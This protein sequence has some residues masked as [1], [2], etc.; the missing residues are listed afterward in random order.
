MLNASCVVLNASYEP[1]DIKPTKD[2][3]ID[4]ILDKA[5]PLKYHDY[6]VRSQHLEFKLPSVIALNRYVSSRKIY[7]KKAQLTNRNLFTRDNH[8]CQYCG[9][10]STD[11]S[12]GDILTR[13]H[14]LPTSKG[15]RDIWEN[16]TTACSSCNNKK[17]NFTL[18]EAKMRLRRNPHVPTVFELFAKSKI[19]R[20]FK[21]FTLDDMYEDLYS[22]VM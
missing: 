9:T 15:G 14:V 1:L 4:C 5:V 3:L 17:D 18:K 12:H 16:V 2:A 21:D 8:Q 13:D 10:Y 22:E 11:L 7:T 6:T 20:E 19:M